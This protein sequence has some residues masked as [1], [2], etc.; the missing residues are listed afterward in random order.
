MYYTVST[1]YL[2]S[3]YTLNNSYVNMPVCIDG[4]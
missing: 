2:H 4:Y 3:I 1:Q